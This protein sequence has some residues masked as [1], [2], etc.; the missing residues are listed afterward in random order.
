MFLL[1]CLRSP[2]GPVPSLN[3]LAEDK[4]SRLSGLRSLVEDGG[5]LAG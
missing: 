4:K 3:F 2:Q 1:L 5:V